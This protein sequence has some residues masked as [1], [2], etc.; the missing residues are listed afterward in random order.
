M[1]TQ[2]TVFRGNPEH[3]VAMLKEIEPTE[4]FTLEASLARSKKRFDKQVEVMRRPRLPQKDRDVMAEARM[5]RY[6]NKVPPYAVHVRG[7]TIPTCK[8]WGL[9][10]DKNRGCLVFPIRRYDGKLVGLSGRYHIKNPPT[11]YHNYAGLDKTRYLY[12]EHL[13]KQGEPIII[14][15]GQID[16]IITWQHLQIPTLAI[17]GEGFSQN[18]ART[19]SAFNPPHV[20]IFP[21]NDPAGHLCAD[22]LEH[23]LRGRVPLKLML[24]PFKMDPGDLTQ[25]EAQAALD[26]AVDLAGPIKWK[27]VL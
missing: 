22:K 13:L 27:D 17:L 18:H 14:C 11:K 1:L 2:A 9:G 19:I 23:G 6:A 5:D 16:A 26:R 15:E 3:L 24:P 20:Y 8:Y 25:E 7:I 4:R 12:G 21:D 10:S